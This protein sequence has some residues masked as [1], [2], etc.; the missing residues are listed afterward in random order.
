MDNKLWEDHRMLLPK[1]REKILHNSRPKFTPSH[2]SDEALARI[3]ELIKFA[4]HFQKPL[5]VTYFQANHPEEKV[6]FSFR[7]LAGYLECRFD[8]GQKQAIPFRAIIN[9]ELLLE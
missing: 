3:E 7:L 6:L 4:Q 8:N 1:M 2:L 5:L 9:V